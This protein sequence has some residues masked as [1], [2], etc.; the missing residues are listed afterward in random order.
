MFGTLGKLTGIKIQP[1]KG[2]VKVG[3]PLQGMNIGD[4]IN[5]AAL[6]APG[7][8]LLNLGKM[9]LK[10]LSSGNILGNL[11]LKDGFQFSD[12]QKIA[13]L[14]PLGL[15]GDKGFLYNAFASQLLG[16]PK[17]R[18]ISPSEL[19][20]LSALSNYSGLLD[21]LIGISKSEL[22]RLGDVSSERAR[23]ATSAYQSLAPGSQQASIDA[24]RAAMLNNARKVANQSELLL[25]TSAKGLREGL[26]IDAVN[27]ATEQGNRLQAE[28]YS[29]ERMTERALL[30]LEALNPNN[31][32][33]ALPLAL[34]G[35]QNLAGLLNNQRQADAYARSN[36]PPSTLEQLLGI[37]GGLPWDKIDWSKV[38]SWLKL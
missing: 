26:L 25:G 13:G 22:G 3:A 28:T 27:R 6:F 32:M 33:T 10:G 38:G 14:N 18:A 8:N 2:K 23:T 17:K 21:P 15:S 24:R 4:W 37:A 31:F 29:P 1:F 9:G 20:G 11:G 34:S 36:K 35:T 16:G 19:T 12:L 30:Q 5:T 7:G